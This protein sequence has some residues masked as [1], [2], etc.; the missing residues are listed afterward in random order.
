MF[1]NLRLGTKLGAGFGML[2]LIAMVLGGIAV[3]MMKAVESDSINLSQEY[4]PETDL[5]GQG[6]TPQSARRTVP[7]LSEDDAQDRQWQRPSSRQGENR[8]RDCLEHGQTGQRRGS[9]CEFRAV[10]INGRLKT[11]GREG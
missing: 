11:E 3:V 9:G 7:P 8:R 6:R 5:A 10:L 2:I 4:V 1:K